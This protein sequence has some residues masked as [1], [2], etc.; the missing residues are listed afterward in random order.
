[1]SILSS[2]ELFN[3]LSWSL[4]FRFDSTQR[5]VM[6]FKFSV[7]VWFWIDCFAMIEVSTTSWIFVQSVSFIE[8]LFK[9]FFW[10]IN[11]SCLLLII[12]TI[13]VIILRIFFLINFLLILVLSILPLFRCFRNWI[14]VWRCSVSQIISAVFAFHVVLLSVFVW[15]RITILFILFIIRLINRWFR[16]IKWILWKDTFL[17]RHVNYFSDRWANIA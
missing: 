4:D 8:S 17:S 9:V 10:R 16:C 3:E 5:I 7:T 12:L 2:L 6:I 14:N 13:N 15:L 11:A 1:M